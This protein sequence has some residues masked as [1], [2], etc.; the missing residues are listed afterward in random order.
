VTATPLLYYTISNPLGPLTSPSDLWNR[1][2]AT[3]A[4][5]FPEGTRSV[6]FLGRKADTYCYGEGAA[7]G[8]P[9]YPDGSYKGEHGYPYHYFIWA[10][11]A[12]DLLAVKAGTIQPWAVRPY[13]T[14]IVTTPFFSDSGITGAAAWDPAT[15][16][17][18][19][20][21]PYQDGTLPVVHVFQVGGGTTPVSPNAPGNPRLQ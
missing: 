13:A 5:F 17:V 10:F 9:S 20:V 11:D 3:S 1:A 14:W 8:D 7:C 18:Y 2:Y 4:V 15:R 16:R 12:I 21:M 19:M 6:L